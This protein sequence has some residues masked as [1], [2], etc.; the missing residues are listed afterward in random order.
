MKDKI[1]MLVIG[2]LVG[3]VIATGAFYVYSKSTTCNN[4]NNTQ[5]QMNGSQPP[6]LPSG[7]QGSNDGSQ[8]MPNNNNT[9]N[10]N[11]QESN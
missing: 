4:T 11:T 6:E 2:L 8:G 7:Q 3:A 5:Q 10:S 1:I 9:Q